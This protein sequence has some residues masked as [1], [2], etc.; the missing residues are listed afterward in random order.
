MLR[1]K[2]PLQSLSKFEPY[3]HKFFNNVSESY[4]I[5]NSRAT[6]I[7]IQSVHVINRSA[8][9][10]EYRSMELSLST[11]VKGGSSDDP[12]RDACPSRSWTGAA[13]GIQRMLKNR[14]PSEKLSLAS[15]GRHIVSIESVR[16]DF[17][18][19]CHSAQ[20]FFPQLFR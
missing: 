15:T 5:L 2:L 3:L 17:P 14:L 4:V 18:S 7:V 1:K 6:N 10:I 8:C 16:G 19:F 11:K 9:R 13:G 20:G 12:I